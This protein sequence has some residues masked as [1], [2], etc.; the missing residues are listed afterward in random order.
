MQDVLLRVE[1]VSK[2]YH[3]GAVTTRV[4]SEVEL[5]LFK[6]EQLAIVGSSGSGKSTLLHIMGTLDAPSS[7]R[8]LLLEEDLYR[9]SARRQSQ[10]RNQE[11]GFIYQFHHLLPE[12]TA[13]ENVAM[14]AF[15]QG[16]ARQQALAEAGALLERVGLGHRMS[17]IPAELSGGERQRV[18]IARALINKPKLVLAD[19]PTGNLDAVSGDAVYALI[20]ELAEQLGT[21]FVV[22]T[23]DHKLASRMDRQVTMK[24]GKLQPLSGLV[25]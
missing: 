15:I 1:N 4:L 11:L 3:D 2:D 8:V 6:G 18:A 21:A 22:V 24:D 20:R 17:H 19:E 13:L 16:R 10:I 12:F 7:G 9:V 25:L 5:Q 14:P 23:H